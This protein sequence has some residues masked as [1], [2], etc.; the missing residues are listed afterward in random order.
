MAIITS[1]ARHL[2]ASLAWFRLRFVTVAAIAG[3]ALGGASA[4]QASN[5]SVVPPKDYYLALGDSLAYGYQQA[6]FNA[7]YPSVNPASFNTGYVDDFTSVLTALSPGI[8]TINDGCP[9]ETTDSFINGGPRPGYCATGNGWPSVWLHHP[10]Q[11]SQLSDAVAFLKAHSRQTSPVTI[12]IGANDLLYV[13]HV[14][15]AGNPACIQANAPAAIHHIAT[16]L[17]TILAP[18]RGAAPTTEIIVIG[19]YDPLFTIQGADALIE[20]DYNPTMAG[21]AAQYGARFADPFPAINYNEPTSVCTLTAICTQLQD[22]HPTDPGYQ[23]M[24]QVIVD[25]S[26]YH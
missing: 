23:A 3:L 12:D 19:L 20:N 4:A 17:A 22:I 11:G 16:N 10:Y 13:L 25:A 9:G 6:K 14:V 2:R 18:L 7:E 15:C 26:G 5:G 1:G 21:V 8:R 24:A